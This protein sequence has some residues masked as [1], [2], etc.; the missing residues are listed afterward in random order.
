MARG[1][2][3]V[4]VIGNLGNDPDTRYTPTGTAVASFSVAVNEKWTDKNTGEIKERVEWINCE[5]WQKTA[6]IIAQYLRKG[7]KVYVEGRLRTDKYEKD[8]QTKYFTKV[9]VDNVQFLD[10]APADGQQ[11]PPA[12]RP[13]QQ[14]P[15]QQEFDDDIPF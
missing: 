9:R 8:G 3:K 5:A 11:R 12:Q 13:A 7:S 4:I 1:I 6:E 2:N 10:S 14:P 15:P